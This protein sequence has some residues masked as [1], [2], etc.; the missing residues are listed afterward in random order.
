MFTSTLAHMN[1]EYDVSDYDFTYTKNI[2][3]DSALVDDIYVNE[4]ENYV[5]LDLNDEMYLYLGVPEDAISALARGEGYGGSVG[6]HYNYVWKG[7]YGKGEHLGN[8]DDV[9]FTRVAKVPAAVGSPKGLSEPNVVNAYSGGSVSTIPTPYA[10]ERQGNPG[11]TRE[12]SLVTPE[13]VAPVKAE[14]VT[15]TVYFTLNGSNGTYEFPS[16]KTTVED[17]IAEVNEFVSRVRGSG[18]V[19][20]VVFEFE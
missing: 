3:V 7:K 10:T 2:S 19:V 6:R 14:G 8:Y 17:A 11:E 18:K 16:D 1:K 4:N 13:P 20:K 15:S 5:V 12:F 9:D